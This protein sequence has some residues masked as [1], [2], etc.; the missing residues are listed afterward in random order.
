MRGLGGPR[1]AEGD[2][3]LAVICGFSFIGGAAAFTSELKA[4]GLLEDST[5][6]GALGR[7][8]IVGE[9]VD[10]SA[11]GEHVVMYA[12]VDLEPPARDAALHYLEAE[13]LA[14]DPSS[15]GALEVT[16]FPGA[17]D[18][19]FKA[20]VEARHKQAMD[21]SARDNREIGEDIA[22]LIG[23]DRALVVRELLDYVEALDYRL[24]YGEL[25]RW[26]QASAWIDIRD[27][28]AV[29]G[30]ALFPRDPASA[31]VSLVKGRTID[32]GLLR[33]LPPRTVLAQIYNQDPAHGYG[34]GLYSHNVVPPRDE[35]L[36][37]FRAK[38]A[39]AWSALSGIPVAEIAAGLDR[40][41]SE[42]R[43]LYDGHAALVA[44]LVS[45]DEPAFALIQRMR[46][47]QSGREQWARWSEAFGDDHILG[48][49]LNSYVEW[50]FTPRVRTVDSAAV[51]RW[52]ITGSAALRD[53]VGPLPQGSA[54]GTYTLHID[55]V[56]HL[57][58]AIYVGSFTGS[59]LA[60]RQALAGVAETAAD[61]AALGEGNAL[62][63][64]N[65]AGSH[66]FSYLGSPAAALHYLR[67]LIG[68]DP[69]FLELTAS[70]IET[71]AKV[72]ESATVTTGFI[73]LRNWPEGAITLEVGVGQP[74]IDLVRRAVEL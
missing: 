47:G 33:K 45:D 12:G 37:V 51:D 68:A 3:A 17:I 58:Y 13:L 32:P 43:Q 2:A 22:E 42:S 60:V 53:H 26:R 4:G 61:K 73:A 29:I 55:R 25:D 50:S 23:A 57:G 10:I 70:A 49:E 40:H 16:L 11:S 71:F 48:D 67:A 39:D 24:L 27:D 52:T 56:E 19:H 28:S 7:V 41:A 9:A 6:D 62:L 36:R 21:T 31:E 18:E 66:V 59:E 15:A 20:A 38:F 63:L 1:P 35:D 44:W 30:T 64:D 69:E 8:R 65:T 14:R 74:F 5:R 54:V 72:P 46:P 34:L